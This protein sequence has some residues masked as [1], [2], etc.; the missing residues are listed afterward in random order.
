MHVPR[1]WQKGQSRV[2]WESDWELWTPGDSKKVK[3]ITQKEKIFQRLGNVCDNW[4]EPCGK[5][6][7]GVVEICR[8]G[9][10]GTESIED[11]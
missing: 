5:E 8:G 2:L 9:V 4:Y 6:G 1:G 10:G 7:E 11:K 3:K